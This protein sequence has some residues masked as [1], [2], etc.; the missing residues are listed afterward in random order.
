[1][2][3]EKRTRGEASVDMREMDGLEKPSN[4]ED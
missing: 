3:V 2:S 4:A 1:M